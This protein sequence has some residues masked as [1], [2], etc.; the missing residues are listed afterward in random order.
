M[1]PQSLIAFSDELEKI[2]GW[3][4]LWQRFVDVFRTEDDKTQRRVNLHFDPKTVDTKWDKF[5][6]R[7]G[8]PSYYKRFVRH[9]AVDEK[10]KLHAESMHNLQRANTL[11]KIQSSRLPGRS[12]E[13]RELPDGTLG[14]TC[15]DWRF[16]GSVN[17]G[18]ECKH[19][20]AFKR[21]IPRVED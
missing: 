11:G 3:K 5:L 10:L 21:G 16:K 14:C 9:P 2:A 18:Y 13:I 4:S 6:V 7:V 12:Y 17:P 8:D 1:N 15:P 19:I 20:K